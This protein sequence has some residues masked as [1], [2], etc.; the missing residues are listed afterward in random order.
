MEPVAP[1]SF[2][3]LPG[4]LAGIAAL[5][6]LSLGLAWILKRGGLP[7]AA[8]V[9]GIVAGLLLGPGVLGRLAPA[10]HDRMFG[11]A[12][13]ELAKWREAERAVEAT[14]FA[15]G[16]SEVD[17]ESVR[18][19]IE[20][21]MREADA[22]KAGWN[23]AVERSRRPFLAFAFLLAFTVIAAASLA[24]P[25]EASGEGSTT[26]RAVLLGAWNASMPAVLAAIGLAWLGEP[27]WTSAMFATMA[28]VAVGAWPLQEG[29]REPAIA[30]V[31]GGA[32]SLRTAAV[33]A[34]LV[35]IALLAAAVGVAP[36]AGTA[37]GLS[38]LAVAATFGPVLAR[39]MG[40]ERKALAAITLAVPP[41]AALAA[42]R[43]EPFLDFRWGMVIMLALIAEDGRWIGGTLGSWLPGG[44]RP[45][46]AIGIGLASIPAGPGML[47]TVAVGLEA[48][49]LPPPVAAGLLVG[50]LLIE[51]LAP[52]RGRFA[53]DSAR[54]ASGG[55]DRPGP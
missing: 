29:D 2:A 23:A 16:Q 52:I 27:A 22:R 55:D 40:D 18:V 33:V 35:A 19:E 42:V 37:V 6:G 24:R 7:G 12:P 1:E 25:A 32:A 20:S 39:A 53:A 45:F 9:G 5:I 50:V 15:A 17:A 10:A 51:V 46:H 43:V 48:G 31:P 14:A 30:V 36:H 54:I 38:A 28:A 44:I 47:A 4:W 21:L 41:L 34:N 11:S 8:A 13:E 3:A 49:F 26:G